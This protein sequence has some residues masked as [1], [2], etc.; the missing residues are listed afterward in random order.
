MQR[1]AD[2]AWPEDDVR[3]LL[4]DLL[5]AKRVPEMIRSFVVCARMVLGPVTGI[6]IR[7]ITHATVLILWRV[8]IRDGS[9]CL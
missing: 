3:T 9:V 7:V 4:Q 2:I 6:G 1:T 5:R 8:E